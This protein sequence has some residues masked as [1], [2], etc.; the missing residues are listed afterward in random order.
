[1]LPLNEYE[2]KSRTSLA[3]S[4][5]GDS[6]ADA[7]NNRLNSGNNCSGATATL[8]RRISQQQHS[9][10]GCREAAAYSGSMAPSE[11]ATT[12]AL[13]FPSPYALSRVLSVYESSPRVTYQ[14]QQQQQQQNPQSQ[15]HTPSHGLHHQTPG[16]QQQQQK[17][18]QSQQQHYDVPFKQVSQVKSSP[19]LLLCLRK[20]SRE[21]TGTCMHSQAAHAVT[22]G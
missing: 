17:H 20:R 2:S 5:S 16:H 8:G 14:Q 11:G 18:H 12:T 10:S 3:F 19:S 6:E 13:Y 15:P 21:C 1:M 9:N 4:L 22:C 7:V